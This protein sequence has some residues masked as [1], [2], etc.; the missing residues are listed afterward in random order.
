MKRF[1]VVALFVAAA[2]SLA[3]AFP[4]AAATPRGFEGNWQGTDPDGSTVTLSIRLERGSEGRAFQM[5][6]FD[7]RGSCCFDEPVRGRGVG[8]S[9]DAETMEATLVWWG[10]RSSDH[11]FYPVNTTFLYNPDT[12]T[13]TDGLVE[14]HRVRPDGG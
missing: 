13:L 7:D 14:Y 9:W 5:M 11:I 2:F 8:V 3:A 6:G 10:L 4:G 12:D 1:G